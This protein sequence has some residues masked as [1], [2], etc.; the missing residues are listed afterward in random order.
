[1]VPGRPRHR[2]SSLGGCRSGTRTG[3][4]EGLSE[5][6]AAAAPRSRAAHR[7]DT[8]RS[9]P[10][11]NTNHRRLSTTRHSDC[12]AS[13][14]A[15]N[16]AAPDLSLVRREVVKVA[17]VKVGAV[18]PGA[19]I[20]R[21]MMIMSLRTVAVRISPLVISPEPSKPAAQMRQSGRRRPS[22]SL[23]RF[24]CD[25]FQLP[26]TDPLAVAFYLNVARPWQSA[27]SDHRPCPG[28]AERRV[29]SMVCCL[30]G[31]GRYGQDLGVPVAVL[32]RIG[33]ACLCARPGQA[34]LSR[35]RSRA[36]PGEG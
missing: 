23:N 17:T 26:P 7:S 16:A 27:V 30:I 3:P 32:S 9:V 34:N 8:D 33:R 13:H 2:G 18:K 20:V 28:A 29:L 10:D 35:S 5:P 31:A 36:L 14:A 19:M 11:R 6:G 15:Q 4:A 22:T 25:T 21:A 24:A 1:M 12:H